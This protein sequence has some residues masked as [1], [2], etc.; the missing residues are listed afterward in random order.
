MAAVGSSARK[1]VAEALGTAFLLATVVGSGIMGQ[2]LADGNTALALLANS[3]ATAG[4]LLALILAFGGIS[5][6]HFNPLVTFI[7]AFAG[8]IGRR[9]VLGF[10][11]AQLLGAVVGVLLAH[12][13]F[14]APFVSTS[15]QL[16]T[17][18]SQWLSEVIA[19]FGLIAVIMACSQYHPRKTPFAVAG[20]IAAAY[21][22]TASTSFANPAVTIA[23][24]LTATFAGIRPSDAPA[25]IAAQLTGASLAYVTM[26]WL[27]DDSTAASAQPK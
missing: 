9:T 24:T 12:A 17:G 7:E 20:Y 26:R 15:L 16:R 19:T 22:F 5:G 6:A 21:W 3:T 18:P 23:R 8:R 4:S 10:V 25:F 13:M 11:L 1:L 2:R 27:L 14:E